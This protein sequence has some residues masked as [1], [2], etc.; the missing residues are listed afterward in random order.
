MNGE[1]LPDDCYQEPDS[2]FIF[3]QLGKIHELLKSFCKVFG[4]DESRLYANPE[5]F[6]DI[7]IRMDERRLYFHIFHRRMTP[8]ECK[9]VALFIF[10][11]LKLRP[12][13]IKC[14]GVFSEKQ[15]RFNSCINEK[16]CVFI[17]ISLLKKHNPE[18][19]YNQLSNGNYL[20][21]LAYS[22][23]FRDLS[24]EALYLIFDAFIRQ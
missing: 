15:F 9:M 18:K 16:F 14:D 7:I 24:K 6:R 10:W 11:V 1:Y 23:R 19:L 12:L 13:T 22:F 17:L 8:N 3:S 5:T 2:Q 4:I 21:E 20:E